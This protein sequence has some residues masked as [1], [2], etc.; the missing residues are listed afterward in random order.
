MHSAGLLIVLLAVSRVL[1]AQA[2]VYSAA[3]IVNSASWEVGNLA[4]YTFATIFGERLADET[5]ARTEADSNIPGLG[6]VNVR[7]NDFEAMVFYISPEQV[8]FLIPIMWKAEPVKVRLTKRGLSGPEVILELKEYAPALFQL[9]AGLVVAQRW[10]EYAV[11]TPESP[12]RPGDIV[13]LYATGLGS[14]EDLVDDS[15]PLWA[16]LEIA[17]R[18]GFRVLLNSTPV[19]DSNI[20]YAGAVGQHWGLYQINLRLPENVPDDPTIQI[21]IGDYISV[22]DIRLPVRRQ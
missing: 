19:E 14:F 22:P 12:A 5:R 18:S 3:G 4:P 8:N 15:A 2:P 9:D 10:P 17:A 11:V 1:Y 20:L 21:A 7:V 13:V 16:P 6:A